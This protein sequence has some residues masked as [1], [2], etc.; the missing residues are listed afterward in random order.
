MSR[1]EPAPRRR[2]I[3]LHPC[4]TSFPRCISAVISQEF[5]VC[6]GPRV[7]IHARLALE[8]RMLGGCDGEKRSPRWN[9]AGPVG[10]HALSVRK[11]ERTSR[12]VGVP[13]SASSSHP[14][15]SEW[16]LCRSESV[17]RLAAEKELQPRSE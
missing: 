9:E 5:L 7:A 11:H 6:Y 17:R 3:V 8:P 15:I 16:S 1:P 2:S 4:H 12:R 10:Q 13:A 14:T